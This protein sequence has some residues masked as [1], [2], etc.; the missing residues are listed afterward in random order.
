MLKEKKQKRISILLSLMLCFIGIVDSLNNIFTT[1]LSG[2]P[3]NTGVI[4]VAYCILL[5]WVVIDNGTRI[6]RDMLFLLIVTGIL[7]LNVFVVHP[8]NIEYMWTGIEDIT[9]NPIFV[10][11]VFSYVGYFVSR[12]LEDNVIFMNIFEKF[13]I[14]T[15]ILSFIRYIGDL[16]QLSTGPEYMN[17]SYGLL[18]PTVFITLLC[19][20][21]F[22]WYRMI[23]AL[24]GG[25]LIFVAGSRGALVG[26]LVSIL[27]YI[28]FYGKL[29]SNRKYGI[30]AL[31]FV[32]ASI[33]AFFS[34]QILNSIDAMLSVAGI[35]SRTIELLLSFSFF[36]DS[37]RGD[38]LK[39]IVGEL[40][41][42]GHGLWGDRVVLDGSYVH[43]LVI[44]IL[45]DFGWILGIIIIVIL[46]RVI[47]TGLKHAD[48]KM[49]IFLCSLF[50]VGLIKLF[51]SSSFLEQE[52]AFYVL[53]GMSI[54]SIKQYR[55]YC[56]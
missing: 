17:F 19:I 16:K 46:A 29:T 30:F 36:N 13:S 28:F 5:L 50:S 11:F 3:I 14:F 39:D 6:S 40:E 33:V 10:F 21:S 49:A 8:Q 2:F 7:F 27:I 20:R 32:F 4:Y 22:N 56:K 34:R 42:L 24:L 9:S 45:Y 55:N 31:L 37:G 48:E 1:L 41:F 47:F 38:I 52:P 43:N 15:I 18:L 44:E 54:N 35:N 12:R 26:G 53:L 25:L 23:V 51:F